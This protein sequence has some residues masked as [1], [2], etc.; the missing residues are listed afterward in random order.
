MGTGA[1]GFGGLNPWTLHQWLITHRQPPP[2]P[3]TNRHQMLDRDLEEAEE[4]YGMAVRAHMMVLDSLL[5]LQVG[6]GC[7]G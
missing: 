1:E 6:C 2:A 7:G 4:Q 5:D 3:T